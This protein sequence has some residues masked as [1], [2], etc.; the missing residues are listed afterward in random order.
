VFEGAD[1]RSQSSFVRRSCID[2]IVRTAISDCVV[3]KRLVIDDRLSRGAQT[4]LKMRP[5]LGQIRNVFSLRKC[6]EQSSGI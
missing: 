5:E 4:C 2:K 6:S 3:I 1:L